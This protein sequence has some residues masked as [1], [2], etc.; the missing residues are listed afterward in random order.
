[1]ELEQLFQHPGRG[2]RRSALDR[3]W[4]QKLTDVK[5]LSDVGYDWSELPMEE[6]AELNVPDQDVTENASVIRDRAHNV[7]EQEAVPE[8][9]LLQVPGLDVPDDVSAIREQE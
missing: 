7:M 9:D 6:R 4:T 5:T 1:M 2:V 3:I 8:I